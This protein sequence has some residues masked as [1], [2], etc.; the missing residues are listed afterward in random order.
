[1]FIADAIA[2]KRNQTSLFG[3][4]F[5]QDGPAKLSGVAFTFVNCPT[6]EHQFDKFVKT[7]GLVLLSFEGCANVYWE[8]IKYAVISKQYFI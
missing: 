2:V 4:L 6:A 1:M 5:Q 8:Q 3:W 7:T